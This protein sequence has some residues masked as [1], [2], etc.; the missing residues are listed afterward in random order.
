MDAEDTPKIRLYKALTKD[1]PYDWAK[2]KA[3]R[4]AMDTDADARLRAALADML[5]VAERCAWYVVRATQ[6]TPYDVRIRA[7]RALLRLWD[8]SAER[9]AQQQKEDAA[10]D[11][12]LRREGSD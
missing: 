9:V 1:G 12:D 2:E 11:A 3:K 8:D 10:F 6:T 4:D 7:A 5:D